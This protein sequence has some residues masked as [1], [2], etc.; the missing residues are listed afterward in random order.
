[1]QNLYIFLDSYINNCQKLINVTCVFFNRL[2]VLISLQLI[3]VS[4]GVTCS[5]LLATYFYPRVK[6]GVVLE[7]IWAFCYI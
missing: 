4:S 1:M 2:H 7:E 6:L 5:V 3:G